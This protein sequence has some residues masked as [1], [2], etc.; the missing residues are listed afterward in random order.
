MIR[1]LQVTTKTDT[2]TLTL[3]EMGDIIANKGTA[4][5]ITVVAAAGYTGLWYYFINIGAGTVTVAEDGVGT[6]ATLLQN[7][8][9]LIIDD[10]TTWH[11]GAVQVQTHAALTEAHGAT[12]AVVGTTNV[13]TLTNKTLTSPVLTT[14]LIDDS[15]AGI[16]VTSADQT[17]ATP[18][19]TI[20][21]IVDAAD[22]FVMKDTAQTLT[23]KT[24][25]AP[26]L[27]AATATSIDIG[28]TTLIASRTITIDTG[29]AFNIVLAAASGDDFT[30][31]TTKLIV[32]GDSGNVG[33]GITP[34]EKLQV[35]GNIFLTTDSQKIL[36]GTGKDMSIYY[37]G[38][39]G[40][41]KTDEIA[42][43]DLRITT[44]AAKTLELDTAV[45]KDINS[46]GYLLTRPTSSAPDIDTF[47]DKNG[48]DT[49]I[50]TYAF[51]V[52]QYVSGGFELQH[53]YKNGTNLV[54]HV[55][56]QG[57]A[58]PT[59]TDNVQWRLTYIVCRDGVVLEPAVTIDSPDTVFD[60]Q[61]ECV[62]T[63]FAAI[64]GT[65]FLV[66]DQFMFNLWRVA[67]TGDAYAGDALIETAGIHVQVNTL[68][69]RGITTK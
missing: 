63:D 26:V 33:I 61:Y 4:F 25:T 41:I 30:V 29:A 69:S 51:A 50:P 49:A 42:A 48:A 39:D 15:D 18:V 60:T 62:R 10:G 32:E 47:V 31:D 35:S 45:Y 13:Q 19:A 38:T 5:T 12:G 52:D 1:H 54:F 53:D 57:I 6:L 11:T 59:G 16:T 56:W 20:P 40:F 64:D 66:G 67:A 9:C 23:N 2:A 44:G 34:T 27:G 14:P 22:E 37:D 24:L 17:H 58:A 36:F 28:G 65:N 21:D 7:E 55:H 68:G 8:S 43:S 3:A 46:A